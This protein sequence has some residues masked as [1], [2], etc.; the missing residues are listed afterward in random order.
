MKIG[1]RRVLL[2][3]A[4]VVVL[5]LVFIKWWQ[6][7]HR[8][9]FTVLTDGVT[10]LR[11]P[12]RYT[13]SKSMAWLD[14]V[15]GLDDDSRNVLINIPDEEVRQLK[16]PHSQRIGGVVSLLTGRERSRLI[17]GNTSDAERIRERLLDS[18]KPVR[19]EPDS[20]PGLYRVY[21][22]GMDYSWFTVSADPRKITGADVIGSCLSLA[23]G[24]VKRCYIQLDLDGVGFQYYLNIDN[25]GERDR[26]AKYLTQLFAQWKVPDVHR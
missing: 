8:P 16:L 6:W 25:L 9:E 5:G 21:D 19:I 17:S 12:S 14:S 7:D 2:G 18:S 4:A 15:K 11:V 24:E 22:E 20:I 13:P 3:V 1:A 10:T 23:N 26:L